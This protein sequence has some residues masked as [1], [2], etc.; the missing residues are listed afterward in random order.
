[1]KV[2]G[3]LGCGNCESGRFKIN[4]DVQ[5]DKQVWQKTSAD[6]Q[7]IPNWAIKEKKSAVKTEARRS[8]VEGMY[9]HSLSAQR[10]SYESNS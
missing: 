8:H 7:G 1:M 6:E 2:K 4:V 9:R 10:W 3:V 5:K